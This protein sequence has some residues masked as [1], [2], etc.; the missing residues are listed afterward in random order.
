MGPQP[1][2]RFKGNGVLYECKG[3]NDSRVGWVGYP[4][5]WKPIETSG[6]PFYVLG[7]CNFKQSLDFDASFLVNFPSTPN[8]VGGSI[9][10]TTSNLNVGTYI[11]SDDAITFDN[12]NYGY[13]ANSGRITINIT[14]LKSGLA[15]GTFSGTLPASGT[16]NFNRGP[17]MNIT[18]GEFSNVPVFE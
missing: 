4:R 7:F 10:I 18:E 16:G 11:N 13:E 6:Q 3:V 15:S 2:L 14:S 12:L 9:T 5:I 1:S 8:T 17:L